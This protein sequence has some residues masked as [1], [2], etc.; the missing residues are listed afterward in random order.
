MALDLS[1]DFASNCSLDGLENILWFGTE[2]RKIPAICGNFCFILCLEYNIKTMDRFSI[3][4][5]ARII[6][7]HSSA[8]FLYVGQQ[9]FMGW[10]TIKRT[11][12]RNICLIILLFTILW[13]GLTFTKQ[14]S[15]QTIFSKKTFQRYINQR[16]ISNTSYIYFSST[17]INNQ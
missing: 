11:K 15:K 7:E 5:I 3:A 8:T 6:H 10:Y 2:L 1:N 17:H 14:Y 12:C 16:S 4:C 9:F 13:L